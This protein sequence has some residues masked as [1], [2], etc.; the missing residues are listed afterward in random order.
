MAAVGIGFQSPYTHPVPTEKPVGIP[1]PHGTPIPTEPRNP[2]Y[3]YPTSCL[4]SLDAYFTV[5]Y[6]VMIMQEK[7][8]KCH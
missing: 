4:F 5:L 6:S 7:L 3:L 1:S 8:K 2:P